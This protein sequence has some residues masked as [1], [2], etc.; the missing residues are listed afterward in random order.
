[1]DFVNKKWSLKAAVT[2]TNDALGRITELLERNDARLS[3]VTRE[4]ALPVFL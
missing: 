2:S 1:M 3:E 4:V